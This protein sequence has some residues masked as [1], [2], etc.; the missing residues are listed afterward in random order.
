MA[1]VTLSKPAAQKAI[2]YSQEAFEKLIM[3]ANI[4]N[5]QVNARFVGLK[6]PTYVSYLELATQMQELIGQI[7]MKMESISNYCQSI[8]HLIDTYTESR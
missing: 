5:R 1:Q 8:I 3:N 7:G 4:M 2:T 6:D